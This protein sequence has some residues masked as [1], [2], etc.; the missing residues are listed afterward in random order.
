VVAGS[1][2]DSVSGAERHGVNGP[3]GRWAAWFAAGVLLL[4]A[5]S[6]D[7]DATDETEAPVSTTT[8]PGLPGT[9]PAPAT[10]APAAEPALTIGYLAP[11]VGLLNALGIGQQRGLTLAVDEINAA[12]GVLGGPIAVVTEEE[13]ADR[14]I[15]AVLDD[16]LAQDPDVLVG[17]VG[18]ASAATVTPLLADRGLLACSASA[19]A[20]SLTAEVDTDDDAP[21]TFV[22]TALRD[23]EF[24]RLV[25]DELMTAD[26]KRDPAPE[27]VMIVGR[28][29]VYG[30]QLTAGL[31]AELTARNADVS[32]L[33]YPPRRVDFLDEASAVVAADPDVVVLAAYTEAPRLIARIVEAGYDADRIVGL[34]GLLV[35]RLA[36]QTFPSDPPRADGV[37]VLGTTGDRALMTRLTAVPAVDDQVSYGPQM[38][39]CVITLALAAVASGSTEPA[40]IAEQLGPVTTDGR[41][42]STF[43]HCVELLAAG[44]DIDYDGTTGRIAFDDTG[45][46]TTAR[47]VDAAVSEGQLRPV[48]THDVDLVAERQQEIFDSAVFVAQLQQA[49]KVLGYYD[50]D[51]TGIYDDATTAAVKALQHDLGLPETGEYDEATDAA[52]R[53]RL[54]D[55]LDAFTGAVSDLQEALTELGYYSGPI[56]GRYSAETVAAVKAFQRDLGVPSTGVIDVAT[57]RAIHARGQETGAANQPGPTTTTTTPRPVESTTTVTTTEATTTTAAPPPPPTE[58]PPP[59]TIPSPESTSAPEPT[60]PDTSPP[61]DERTLYE[62]LLA[63]PNYSTLVEVAR[64]AGYGTDFSAPGPV[65]LFAPTNDA[66]EALDP[67]RL[68]ELR[69]DAGAAD[70]LLRDLAVEGAIASDE[71]TT[72]EL[73]TIGGSRVD[74]VVDG[75][76]D[77][78]TYAGA[79]VVAP[80]IRASNGIAHGIDAVPA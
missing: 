3:R 6:D 73:E 46:I 13:S 5:C 54:G 21:L 66:F 25:A 26:G 50:D 22:R 4:A 40:A 33:T 12:G 32:T 39:D 7:D 52:L 76:V 64:A 62:V 35:P 8:S 34:D 24:A 44:E 65:T 74:V 68:D 61:P 55:R 16:L 72:G 1:G 41:T 15:D 51:V 14:P 80:D 11:G 17:P 10:T 29:D 58:A 38:Y 67:E 31:S 77:T 69:T 9:A 47:L 49:L 30:N 37:R 56:D 63:D 70:A 45:D 28:D 23:D 75:D 79:T 48:S 59:E 18:S 36:E 53:E 60:T 78:V 71:L 57:L 42:C 19:T 2:T 27:T 20:T 43:A